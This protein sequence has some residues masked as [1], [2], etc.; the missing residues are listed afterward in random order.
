MNCPG[1]TTDIVPP[2]WQWHCEA[3]V[4]TGRPPALTL[5]EPIHGDTMAGAQGAPDRPPLPRLELE[6]H[7]PN[8]WMLVNAVWSADLPTALPPAETP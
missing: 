5:G 4:N 1:E 3:V 8:R 6:E 2:Y 7:M